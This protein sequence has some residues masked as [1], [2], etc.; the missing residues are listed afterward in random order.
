MDLVSVY[1]TLF[2]VRE[3]ESFD[4]GKYIVFGP[5]LAGFAI[6]LMYGI[7]EYFFIDPKEEK[8]DFEIINEKAKLL[9]KYVTPYLHSK[10]ST[11]NSIFNP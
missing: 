3:D 7:Y 1:S 6:G 5:F 8:K 9:D 11:N 4:S 2:F 10:N